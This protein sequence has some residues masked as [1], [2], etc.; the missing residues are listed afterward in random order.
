M[1]IDRENPP[2]PRRKS[3]ESW[4]GEQLGPL[5]KISYRGGGTQQVVMVDSWENTQEFSILKASHGS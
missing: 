1:N 4:G 3:P 5:D 2:P